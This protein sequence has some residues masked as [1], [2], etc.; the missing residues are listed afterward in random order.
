MILH[1]STTLCINAFKKTKTNDPSRI[2]QPVEIGTLG[3]Y[4]PKVLDSIPGDCTDL[5]RGHGYYSTKVFIRV[6]NSFHLR[7]KNSFH[8]LPDCLANN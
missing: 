3:A 2:A 4:H 1:R 7:V 6:R 8:L 5:S